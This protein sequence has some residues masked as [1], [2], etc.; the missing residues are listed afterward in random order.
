[1]RDALSFFVAGKLLILMV[2]LAGQVAVAQQEVEP[3]HAE[4]MKAGLRL[5]KQ[6]VRMTLEQNCLKCHNARSKKADFDLSTRKT[7]VESGHLGS[8]SEDSYLMQLVRH[9][10]VPPMPLK[11]DKLSE[12][13]ISDLAAWIDLGAPYDKPFESAGSAE[14]TSR[15][16]DGDRQF[17]SFAPLSRPDVP[18]VS[19]RQ[20]CRTDIDRFI[21][22]RLEH[23]RIAPNASADRRILIRRVYF[24]LIG[25]PP[26]PV[27]I[28]RFIADTR[29]R[30]YAR[31]ID[32]LLAS[33]HYGERWARHWLD[34]ARFGESS[35]YEHDDDRRNA[36]HYRD[37][38]IKAFNDDLPFDDFIR[39]QIAG[40]ELAPDNPLAYMATGFL[41][42]GPFATQVTE[43]EFE[44]TRYDELDDMVANTGIAFLG[45]SFGCARCHDHKFDPIPAAD[46]YSLAAVFAKAVRGE[47]TLVLEP[48]AE[49]TQVQVTGEGFRPM[50]TFSDGRG[51]RHFY[52]NVYRLRRGDVHQKE[53]VA[54]PGYAQVLMRGGRESDHWRADP[55]EDWT[56]SNF[57]RTSLANWITDVEDGAGHLA[58]RVIVNRLWQ[59]H[60][61]NGLVRTPND[62]GLRGDRPSHPKLL[63]WL[64]VELIEND[65]SLKH[66]H[67][68]ILHS[69][70][71]RQTDTFDEQRA[72]IDREEKLHW[73][74]TPRRIEAEAIRDSMLHVSGLLDTSMHGPGTLDE[75]MRRRSIYFTVKRSKLIPTMMLFD[76]PEHLV[77]IG[78]R[79]VTTTA[80]QAL[81]MMNNQ[82]TR[83]YA[84]GLAKRLLSR[85]KG[86][87]DE[88]EPR[89]FNAAIS[90][91]YELAYGRKPL[92]PESRL[93]NEFLREQLLHYARMESKAA[94]RAA[95]T[96]FAQVLLSGNEF[97]FIR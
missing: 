90:H 20:W 7:L 39:W 54:R 79:P 36:F 18:D 50:K 91:G 27:E 61:G 94:E 26:N 58:A 82:H 60:F 51:Y 65:W 33:R 55:P 1:M 68:L 97:L 85:V 43:A 95:L 81:L 53:Q 62:F 2:I 96:D 48:A 80:P 74:R 66:I 56:R 72:E 59:H 29:P 88:S 15:I 16:T 23:S 6:S 92:E 24:D 17:W 37:F 38:V 31:M 86:K 44:S 11:E 93:S 4:K 13:Q 14:P 32:R 70:V 52:E 75:A 8:S 22:R 45:L 67:R 73:R 47:T 12:Q 84:D 63:D 69:S 5:F 35:G 46:Y 19:N 64:A 76:W 21:L 9:E 71:Y 28:Q 42:A 10:E 57:N 89:D 41:T 40:D 25:L 87:G 34:V 83:A 77:S 30:A 78:K 49:P 3:R